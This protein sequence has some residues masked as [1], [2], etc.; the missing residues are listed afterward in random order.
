[1]LVLDLQN[2]PG[3]S[4]YLTLFGVIASFLSTFWAYGLTRLSKK[5]RAYAQVPPAVHT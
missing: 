3:V 4:L 5:L 1:M 2:G